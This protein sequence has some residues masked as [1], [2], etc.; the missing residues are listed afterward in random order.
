MSLFKTKPRLSGENNRLAHFFVLGHGSKISRGSLKTGRNDS[1]N[2]RLEN[3]D[4][5]DL[6]R[7]A[8]KDLTEATVQTF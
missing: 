4:M 2:F 7:Y 6:D 1:M 3:K 5:M 8:N